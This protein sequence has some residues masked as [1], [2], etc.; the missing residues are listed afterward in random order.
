M[1]ATSRLARKYGYINTPHE[2]SGGQLQRV[3]LARIMLMNPKLVLLMNLHQPLMQLKVG[4][5]PITK[6][7][8]RNNPSAT[9]S[10]K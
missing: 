4:A 7:Y 5:R 6:N 2:V 10:L 9:Y 8:I 3:V 1:D